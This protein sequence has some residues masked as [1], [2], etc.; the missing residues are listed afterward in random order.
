MNAKLDKQLH[1]LD[2]SLRSLLEELKDYSDTDLNRK[3]NPEA[4]SALQVMHHLMLAESFSTAYIKKK[5]SFNPTLK[6]SGIDDVFKGWLLKAYLNSPFKVKAPKGVDSEVLPTESKF[7]ET[8]KSWK[9][10]RVELRDYLSSLPEEI[11]KKQIYKH[12]MAGKMGIKQML[13][14]HQYHFNRHRK[15]IKKMLY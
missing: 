4:W 13:T 1:Q 12:P 6:K 3:P 10:Q 8:A 9:K 15:Q 7:W 5:L 14:F 2:I 11:L